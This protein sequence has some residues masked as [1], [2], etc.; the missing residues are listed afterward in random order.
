MKTQVFEKSY[1]SSEKNIVACFFSGNYCGSNNINSL[2]PRKSIERNI[3]KNSLF[4]MTNAS[5]PSFLV[6]SSVTNLEKQFKWVHRLF[7]LLLWKLWDHFF[8]T[9]EVVENTNF[10]ERKQIFHWKKYCG[11][12]FLVISNII[13]VMEQIH[14]GREDLLRSIVRATKWSFLRT[15]KSL[16]PNFSKKS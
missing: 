8:M 3:S 7:W 4:T 2:G 9:W 6:Y 13:N 14:K 10:W 1:R 12:F 5:G 15:Q 16:E 11:L